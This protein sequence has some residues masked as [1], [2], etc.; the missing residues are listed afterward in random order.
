MTFQESSQ[1]GG[2]TKHKSH[3]LSHTAS[4]P[5]L[6]LQ[7]IG[8][9]WWTYI[10]NC[11][12]LLLLESQHLLELWRA[13]ERASVGPPWGIPLR[14]TLELLC[15][16][17][18]SLLRQNHSRGKGSQLPSSTELGAVLGARQLGAD[19]L[20]LLGYAPIIFLI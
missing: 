19:Q 7:Y 12:W 5:H 15:G 2:T 4:H 20:C 14:K 18:R 3:S 6:F 8:C 17:R 10:G 11:D 16:V 13:A 1:K 9:N